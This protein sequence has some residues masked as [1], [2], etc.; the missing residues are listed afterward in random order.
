MCESL[1]SMDKEILMQDISQEFEIFR[2]ISVNKADM[3][4]I[5]DHLIHGIS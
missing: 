3:T 1:V 4:H 2:A 5:R